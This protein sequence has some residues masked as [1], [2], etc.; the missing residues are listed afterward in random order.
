MRRRTVI[1]A[2]A[3]CHLVLVVSGAFRWNLL[4]P[5]TASA[6]ALQFYT[7]FSGADGYY[8]FFAPGVGP[9]IRIRLKIADAAGRESIVSL[10]N[11]ESAEA[12][13]RMAGIGRLLPN[14]DPQQNR[15][16]LQS[17]AAA[18]FNNDPQA[19]RVSCLVELYGVA[20]SDGQVDFPSLS[21]YRQGMRPTWITVDGITFQRPHV[22]AVARSDTLD[23]NILEQTTL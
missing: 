9:Q 6:Q 10:R 19:E 22:D 14:L 11:G 1:T 13:L 17:L 23:A 7:T 18:T 12:N 16:L 15:R 2:M 8:G 21:E 3:A 20:R 5:G 4:E